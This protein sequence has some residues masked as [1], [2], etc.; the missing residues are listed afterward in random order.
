MNEFELV[1]LE[2]DLANGKLKKGDV[3]TIVTVYGDGKGYEVEFVTLVGE[4]VA[5]ETLLPH[6]IRSVRGS[7][8]MTVR[9]TAE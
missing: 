2:E 7:E 4:T 8:M 9:D 1:V 3:G 6:Q 5:V